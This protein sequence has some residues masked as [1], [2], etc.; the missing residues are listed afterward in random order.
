LPDSPVAGIGS[1]IC[2]TVQLA[3]RVLVFVPVAHD[4]DHE[5]EELIPDLGSSS[6]TARS[7]PSSGYHSPS[8]SDQRRQSTAPGGSVAVSAMTTAAGCTKLPTH[9]SKAL[10][11][12]RTRRSSGISGASHKPTT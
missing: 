2:G 9:Q 6:V 1:W 12:D 8:L 5:L 7:L 4:L 11:P 3:K 10:R